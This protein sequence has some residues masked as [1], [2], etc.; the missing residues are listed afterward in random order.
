MKNRYCKGMVHVVN[1]GETLFQ[2]SRT[3]RIPLALILRANPYVD[4]YNLKP[5]QEICIPISKP[6]RGPFASN[7]RKGPDNDNRRRGSV[8]ASEQI[9]PVEVVE[10]VGSV[11]SDGS[12]EMDGS[13]E[14][15]GSVEMVRPVRPVESVKPMVPKESVVPPESMKPIGD[16]AQLKSSSLSDTVS[17]V[18]RDS[19]CQTPLEKIAVMETE[20][21]MPGDADSKA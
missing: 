13:V 15:A 11:G 10:S 17:P 5:K 4:V 16:K 9:E 8:G 1:E 6:S 21:T 18:K 12:V 3:Y 19:A 7:Q 2:I 14:S 20:V